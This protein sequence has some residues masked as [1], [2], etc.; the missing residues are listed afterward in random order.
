MIRKD[1]EKY[2]ADKLGVT[3]KEAGDIITV[4][5][6]GI[7]QGL[8]KDGELKV[9]NFGSFKV[10]SIKAH[11][12]INPKTKKMIEIPEKQRITFKASKVMKEKVFNTKKTKPIEKAKNE[13][14]KVVKKGKK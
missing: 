14:K 11:S 5:L 3:L 10:K 8:K 1:L 4:F 7:Q 13:I 2:L 12:G 6:N 9:V